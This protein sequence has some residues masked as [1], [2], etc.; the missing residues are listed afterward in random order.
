MLEGKNRMNIY[1]YLIAWRTQPSADAILYEEAKETIYVKIVKGLVLRDQATSEVSKYSLLLEC[2]RWSSIECAIQCAKV[3]YNI[4]NPVFDFGQCEIDVTDMA[5][6][7]DKHKRKVKEEL[8]KN[9]TRH[10][11]KLARIHQTDTVLEA[12]DKE[13]KKR[14]LRELRAWK[15][16]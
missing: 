4:E 8:L 11:Y 6:V 16:N 5:A 10:G 14:A 9:D 2:S 12:I 7:Y 13:A 3:E 1:Y 15:T